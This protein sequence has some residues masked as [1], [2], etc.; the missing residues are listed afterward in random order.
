MGKYAQDQGYK[1]VVLMT[2]NYQAGKDAMAGF[3][4]AY[5]GEV[6]EEIFTPSASSIS[7]PN[8][9]RSRRPSPTPSSPSCP[10]AWASIS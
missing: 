2:P 5:K 1:R 7:P 4:R 3:K 10:A 8:W 9:P 6:V